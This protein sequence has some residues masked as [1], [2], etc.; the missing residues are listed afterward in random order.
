MEGRTAF[1]GERK[2]E[3]EAHYLERQMER[4]VVRKSQWSFGGRREEINI[5][6]KERRKIK[7]FKLHF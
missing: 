6:I 2:A 4:P 3:R 5:N 7:M 1:K